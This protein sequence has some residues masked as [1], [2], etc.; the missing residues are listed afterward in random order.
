[1]VP[2]QYPRFAVVFPISFS[3]DHDGDGVVRNLSV[4][5]CCVESHTTV[6]RKAYLTVRLHAALDQDPIK[7]AVAVVRWSRVGEFGLEF[8]L[9]ETHDQEC[10]G[11]FLKTLP[12]LPAG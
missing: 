9:M 4:A 12:P 7:V 2:R 10:L 8:I 5:G 3:G 6:D 11:E 1:M